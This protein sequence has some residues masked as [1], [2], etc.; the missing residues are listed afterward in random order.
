[1]R[2]FGRRL[3]VHLIDGLAL[4]VGSFSPLDRQLPLPLQAAHK[5]PAALAHQGDGLDARDD[6]FGAHG[7]GCAVATH[8]FQ[9]DRPARHGGITQ[10][11]DRS[12][13]RGNLL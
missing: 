7:Y 3:L 6:H 8:Q 2:V 9:Q 12:R 4:L 11:H 5:G 13:A 10:Q 1:M